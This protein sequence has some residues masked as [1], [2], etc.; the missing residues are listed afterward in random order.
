MSAAETAPAPA[1]SPAPPPEKPRQRPIVPLQD[2]H[3]TRRLRRMRVLFLVGLL[4]WSSLAAWWATYFY[5]S[6]LEVQRATLRAYSAEQKLDDLEIERQRLNVDEA[7]EEL[8]GTVFAIAPRPLSAEESKYPY[9][10]F[11]GR[12]D[13]LALVVSPE[14]RERLESLLRRK[15]IMLAGLMVLYRM[16][17]GELQLRRQ[18]ESFVHSVT[19]ELKSPLTGLRSLLQSFATLDIPKPERAAYA[20]LG[21][22]EIERLDR[23]VANILLSS[24]LEADAFRPQATEIDVEASLRRIQERQLH[25]FKERGGNLILETNGPLIGHGDEEAVDVIVRNLVDNALKYSEEK[26]VV[27]LNGRTDGNQIVIE[28]QDNGIGLSEADQA[29]IFKKFYRAASG[30]VRHAKGSGLGLF[31]ARGLARAMHG[32]LSVR[33]DGPGAGSTFTLTLP[34]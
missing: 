5:R 32:D 7:R 6:T 27:H 11:R 3:E 2:R 23:L 19:H 20:D 25:V 4:A 29:R 12:L 24:R 18:Q 9:E 28:V 14:E 8:K 1:D 10:V 30:E 16:L 17:V 21:L 33:S 15:M 22:R 34:A 13:G 26:P 31:I